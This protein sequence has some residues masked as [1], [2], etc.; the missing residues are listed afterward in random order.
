MAASLVLWALAY[1]VQQPEWITVKRK[2][3][4]HSYNSNSEP[5][6]LICTCCMTHARR[7]SCAAV[8]IGGTVCAKN[9][10]PRLCPGKKHHAATQWQQDIVGVAQCIMDDCCDVLVP[11][12]MLLMMR[13]TSC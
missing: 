5:H 6:V 13:P 2:V 1:P 9:R 7:G 3:Y 4:W 10:Y 11:C 12:L 8:P